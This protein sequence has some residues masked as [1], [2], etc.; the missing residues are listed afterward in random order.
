[1]NQL[2]T[3]IT[4]FENNQIQ[5]RRKVQTLGVIYTPF[6]IA[7]FMI[8][9]AFKIYLESYNTKIGH[10][11][12]NKNLSNINGILQNNLSTNSKF[13]IRINNIKILDPSCGSGRFLVTIAEFLFEIIKSLKKDESSYDI[14]RHIIETNIFGIDI[15]KK[16]CIISKLRLLNW[17]F[18]TENIDFSHFIYNNPVN[19]EKLDSFLEEFKLNYNISNDD[20]LLQDI[21][22]KFDIIIG[23]PPYV[24]NKKILDSEYKKQLTRRFTSAYKLYDLST[25]FIECAIGLLKNNHG[26]LAFLT[27]NKFLAADH[28]IKLREILLDN[29]HIKEIINISSLPIFK[30]ISAYPIILFL[31]SKS[32]KSNLISIKKAQSVHE[33]LNYRWII[34]FKFD[35]AQ[36][37][38]FPLKAIPL[39]KTIKDIQ[40]IFSRFHS[41]EESFK[42][43]KIIYRPFGFI[44][45]AENTN[46]IH[47]KSISE[48][49]LIL[50]GTGNVCNYYIDFKKKIKISK[51]KYRFPFFHFNDKFRDIWSD[52][53]SEKLIFREIAK[54]LTFVYDSG[55]FANLT[56]LYFIRIPSLDT[57]QLFSLLGILNSE[58]ANQIFKSLWGTLHMS[59]GYLRIN[60][61][62]IKRMPIPET[63]PKSLGHI[64]KIVQFLSQLKYELCQNPNANL[65]NGKTLK[66][67]NKNLNFFQRLINIIVN[68]L[69]GIAKIGLNSHSFMEFSYSLNNIELK[70]FYPYYNHPN[71]RIYSKEELRYYLTEINRYFLHLKEILT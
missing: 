6:Q 43:L 60:G 39:S 2:D 41:L 23:N 70:Y 68:N 42:D 61:S 16:A 15:E 29:T 27:P 48:N 67:I 36:V 3:I 12:H 53:A 18:S 1:M 69:Y 10:D 34:N 33:M 20:F 65:G 32:N 59:Y 56:G 25:L 40:E 38:S 7:Q 54:D 24:E 71:F 8:K 55:L 50:L 14:K 19:F 62:F 21:H 13:A 49:D 28:G 31:L 46:F 51:E 64:S 37:N 4:T 26:V 30:R 58:L 57:I 47:S 17:L 63:L 5:E 45:W 11:D 66:E 22:D 35:Q 44:H 52:L 9:N